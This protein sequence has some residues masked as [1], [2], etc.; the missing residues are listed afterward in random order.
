[1]AEEIKKTDQSE[2][3]EAELDKVAGGAP[4]TFR[5]VRLP[6]DTVP[7]PPPI[8]INDPPLVPIKIRKA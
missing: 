4:D 1:M 5:F 8:P 6:M 3:A 2:L 7:P